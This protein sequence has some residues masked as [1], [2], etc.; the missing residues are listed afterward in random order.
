VLTIHHKHKHKRVHN[1]R[2]RDS[3]HTPKSFDTPLSRSLSS[4]TSVPIEESVQ[5]Y[6][7]MSVDASSIITDE[8]SALNTSPQTINLNSVNI[9]Q[10]KPAAL[11]NDKQ[12][13]LFKLFASSDNATKH[14][15]QIEN[16]SSHLSLYDATLLSVNNEQQ[17]SRMMNEVEM[18]QHSLVGDPP[19]S[20]SKDLNKSNLSSNDNPVRMDTNSTPLTKKVTR[21]NHYPNMLA[22]FD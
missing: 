3:H 7:Q 20:S 14:L 5:K 10:I 15:H 2:R 4:Y 1:H 19:F 13:V 6:T 22:D 11:L 8:Q 17:I 21:I 18:H 12:M 9:K 16:P